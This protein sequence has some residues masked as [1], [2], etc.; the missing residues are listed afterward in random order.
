MLSQKRWKFPFLVTLLTFILFSS[1]SSE[2]N[3]TIS[4]SIRS[5][6]NPDEVSTFSILKKNNSHAGISSYY[7]NKICISGENI[8]SATIKSSC[9]ATEAALINLYRKNNSHVESPDLNNYLNKVCIQCPINSSLRQTCLAEETSVISLFKTTN[10]HV[11]EIGNL[12]LC[13]VKTDPDI[14]QGACNCTIGPG[15]WDPERKARCCGDDPGDTF[16]TRQCN[17]DPGICESNVSDT[18]CC[19]RST[20]CVFQETCYLIYEK[21]DTN[22]DSLNETCSSGNNW[23]CNSSYIEDSCKN[24]GYPYGECLSGTGNCAPSKSINFI[25]DKRYDLGEKVRI[26]ISFQDKESDSITANVSIRYPN[27]TIAIRNESMECHTNNCEYNFTNTSTLGSYDVQVYVEAGIKYTFPWNPSIFSVNKL[28]LTINFEKKKTG[29]G[30]K[31]DVYGKAYLEPSHTPW[32]NVTINVTLYKKSYIGCDSTNENGEY[33]C[34]IVEPTYPRVYQVKVEGERLGIK[35]ST[36]DYLHVVSPGKIEV[37]F[38]FNFSLKQPSNDKI[39]IGGKSPSEKIYY[40]PDLN[41][42][43]L[44]AEDTQEFSNNLLISLLSGGEFRSIEYR[45]YTSTTNHSF[46][47]AQGRKNLLY[48]AFTKG[49]CENV[50][51]RYEIFAEDRYKNLFSPSLGYPI[52]KEY[53]LKISLKY[54]EK[55]ILSNLKLGRGTWD[56]FLEKNGTNEA[57]NPQILIKKI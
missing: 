28:N 17:P 9:N 47:L 24:L 18:E 5:N 37:A 54:P 40:K 6:C 51:N 11:G 25:P 22:D 30:D 1:L 38:R 41:K 55:D 52:K 56:L 57:G 12:N 29:G 2:V 19:P 32:E 35:N 4:S 13:V 15:N 48:L 21:L 43:Y 42:Y 27:D 39:F 44:C 10:S 16:I 33:S 3:L 26:N 36:K 23:T 49:R 8:T 20:D 14:S 34:E 53:K 31:Q 7:G 45:N 46:K 50:K